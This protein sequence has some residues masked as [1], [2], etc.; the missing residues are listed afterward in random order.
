LNSSSLPFKRI[1]KGY[2][3]AFE[4]E[5]VVV[6]VILFDNVLLVAFLIESAERR[7]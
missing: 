7:P 1:A 6:L 4:S 3:A 5:V 2:H